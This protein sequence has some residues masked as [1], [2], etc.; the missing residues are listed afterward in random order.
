MATIQNFCMYAFMAMEGCMKNA[1]IA[2]GVIQN[3]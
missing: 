2:T 1:G 3:P